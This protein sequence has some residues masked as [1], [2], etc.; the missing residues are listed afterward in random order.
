MAVQQLAPLIL[1]DRERA[2]LAALT[3]RRNTAQAL[4]LRAPIVLTCV[5]GGQNAEVAAKL[6]LDGQTVRKWQR[7]F[8]EPRVAGLHDEPLI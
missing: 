2:E 4:A 1:S 8:M 5:A 6:G 7:R 3:M